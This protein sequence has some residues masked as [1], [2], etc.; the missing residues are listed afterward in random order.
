[1]SPWLCAAVPGVVLVLSA[2]VALTPSTPAS[3]AAAPGLEVAST[4][5]CEALTALP[6]EST[7]S[8][9]FINVAHDPLHRLAADPRLSRTLAARVL[10]TM[11]RVEADIASSAH[12]AV[13][14][15]DLGDLHRA[16]LAAL[17][18][19]GIA[20]PSCAL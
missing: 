2:C 7:A 15:H 19:L 20:V 14:G 8:R 12:A 3:V 13:L 9:A 6:V 17:D 16:A 1:M 5:L 10:E 11:Q 18:S 4:G